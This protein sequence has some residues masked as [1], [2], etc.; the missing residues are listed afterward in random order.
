MRT[1][2]SQ[3]LAGLTAAAIVLFLA[4]PAA[5]C[6]AAVEDACR[7]GLVGEQADGYLGVL[8]N[9]PPDV[10]ALVQSINSQRRAEYERIAQNQG[11]SSKDVGALQGPKQFD[12]LQSG[13]YYRDA[14]GNWVKK[15]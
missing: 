7:A 9:A 2:K 10:A 6:P 11:V 12:R 15:P 8:G 3:V 4:G 14:S 5:A 13:Q 1:A